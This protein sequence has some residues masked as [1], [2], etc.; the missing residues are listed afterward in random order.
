MLMKIIEDYKTKHRTL[1][2]LQEFL[3]IID[4]DDT[5]TSIEFGDNDEEVQIE[6]WKDKEFY[7]CLDKD[8]NIIRQW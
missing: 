3:D 7:I 8:Y 1:R 6:I 2:E 4:E 5:Q